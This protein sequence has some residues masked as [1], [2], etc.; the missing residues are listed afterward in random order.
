[1]IPPVEQR[2]LH[3]GV[4]KDLGRG[5]AAEPAANDDYMWD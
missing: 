5:K 2:D 3:V 1:M 4:P